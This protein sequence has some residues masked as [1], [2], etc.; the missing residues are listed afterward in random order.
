MSYINAN[1][2]EYVTDETN[3]CN[4][5]NRNFIRNQLFPLIKERYP[6]VER[7]ISNF[8]KSCKEDNDFI[9]SQVPYECIIKENNTA[10][11]PLTYFA[12]YE[13]SQVNRLIFKALSMI[14]IYADI[15]RKHI[16]LIKDLANYS[17]NGSKIDLPNG[18]NVYK[19]YEY[20]SLTSKRSHMIGTDKPLKPGKIL[21]DN[22]GTI[23]VTKSDN[24]DYGKVTH[25]IDAKKL[26][27]GVV[28]RYRKDGDIFEK[29]GGS[30]KKLKS[31]L[32]DQKI[33]ARIRDQ[34]PVLASGDQIFVVAGMEI[35]NS[36]RIDD[37]TKITYSIIVEKDN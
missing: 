25:M 12:V 18:L 10:R 11:I 23:S 31:F 3:F 26:P 36:V 34:I 35:A 15:E 6:N 22:F 33:P 27:K 24:L 14:G 29:F 30:K 9:K 7:A 4:D 20:I 32:I 28:W 2:I 19:E 13:P 8:G 5:Y 17:E 16:E 37:D 21:F 1:Y